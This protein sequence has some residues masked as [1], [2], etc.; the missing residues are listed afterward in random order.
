MI[1][2]ET[3]AEPLELTAP[4]LSLFELVW[5]DYVAERGGRSDAGWLALPL[6]VLRMVF[7]PSLQL[8][9]LVRLAQKGPRLLQHPIRW[10]QV[11]LFS[12]EI[13]W[14][15]GPDAARVGPGIVFPHPYGIIIGPGVQVGA[16]VAIY[17][18]TNIG[19]D[20]HWVAGTPTDRVPRI[21]DR[22]VIYG[23]TTVQGP[24]TVGH[25][26]VV[27]LSVSLD[28]NVPPGGLKTRNGLRRRGEW[29]GEN[30]A[31]WKPRR[32]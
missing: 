26:A 31:R 13:Y 14:F 11:V 6:F 1:S 30:R 2:E 28:E 25:D 9:L 16:G 21:G 5:S 10:L 24:W 20:R 18:F 7:N 22:A 32:R 8:A 12:S 19:A 3:A 27:G 15:K 4:D 17:N 29:P 23:Y